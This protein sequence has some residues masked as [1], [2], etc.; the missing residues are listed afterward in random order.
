[1]RRAERTRTRPVIFQLQIAV[2]IST[3]SAC[4][5]SR[6]SGK[7]CFNYFILLLKCNPVTRKS[8]F[9]RDRENWR[10]SRKKRE[11]LYGHT[12]VSLFV[13]YKIMNYDRVG[14]GERLCST[15]EDSRRANETQ[16]GAPRRGSF[17]RVIIYELWWRRSTVGGNI[18]MNMLSSPRPLVES[19]SASAARGTPPVAFLFLYWH[20]D[21]HVLSGDALN[22]IFCLQER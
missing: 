4:S 10:K 18:V 16:G 1:M 13:R 8:I 15:R 17:G 2:I 11:F 22:V 19:T 9:T 20:S 14:V 12:T 3:N 5:V 21:M 6:V 7:H